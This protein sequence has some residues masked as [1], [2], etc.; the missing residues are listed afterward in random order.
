MREG[1]R[2]A[3]APADGP[4]PELR[5][6]R[7]V[8]LAPAV[9]ELWAKRSLI[10]VLAER[11]YRVRYK[12]ALLGVGWA[13]LT[14]VSLMLVFTLFLNRVARIESGAAP[15]ALFTY[16][17]LLPWTFFS[18]SVSQG[19]QSLIVNSVLL[20]KVRCPRE[21]FPISSMV[22]A[23]LDMAVAVT[24]LAALFVIYRYVPHVEAYWI[25][26]LLAI[27][28]AFTAGVT[29]LVAAVT[30]R[31][32]DVRHALPIVLQVGLFA[33]PVAYGLDA[34]SP[35]SRVLYAIVNPLAAVIDGYREAILFGRAPDA[36]LSTVA[37]CS[38]LAALLFGY[39]AFRRLETTIAD[40]V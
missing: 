2:A 7:R 40:V 14:P 9:A 10:F 18:T 24:V 37:G 4:P 11:E 34:L 26:A 1:T 23:G 35:T 15:Y 30:V 33:T 16:L 32:R 38:A 31:A 8:G 5:F 19:S 21:V 25:P 17:G 28:V 3:G 27:Q 29:L 6:H 13:V 39:W 12:Q 22:I 36:T 20:T